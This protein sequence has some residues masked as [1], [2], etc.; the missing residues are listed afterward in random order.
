MT[1]AWH[2]R[3][4]TLAEGRFPHRHGTVNSLARNVNLQGVTLGRQGLMIRGTSVRHYIVS[5]RLHTTSVIRRLVNCLNGHKLVRR[6]FVNGAV[7]TGNFQVRRPVKFRVGVR[8]VTHRTAIRRFGNAGLGSLITF[9]I[10]AG[11]IRANNF[12]VRGSL[13]YGYDTRDN[14][15]YRAYHFAI[16]FGCEGSAES[17]WANEGFRQ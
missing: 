14:R 1:N 13:T 15:L 10:H 17:T 9:V 7:C 8:I 5:R 12:N 11:L 16:Q 4:I 3:T 2:V 6:G